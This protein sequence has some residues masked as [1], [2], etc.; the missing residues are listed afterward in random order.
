MGS[1]VLSKEAQCTLIAIDGAL[2]E[3]GEA[4][5]RIGNNKPAER[6]QSVKLKKRVW[7]GC[8]TEDKGENFARSLG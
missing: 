5:L 2:K 1:R 8:V 6:G 7:S 4:I 3:E